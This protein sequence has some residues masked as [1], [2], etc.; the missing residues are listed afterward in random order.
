MSAGNDK[1][2]DW[3]TILYAF[4]NDPRFSV[5]LICSWLTEAEVSSYS[6]VR[7]V[8][9]PTISNFVNLYQQSDIVVV[10][11][12]PN[13]FSGITVALEAA[14]VGVPVISSNTG[15][16][17]TY[18]SSKEVSYVECQ[19]PA[20]L[21]RAALDLSPERRRAQ[22]KRARARFVEDDYS[23]EGMIERYSDITAEILGRISSQDRKRGSNG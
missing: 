22:A 18:F 19:D 1:T 23:S 12:F 2:R 17:A 8:R 7:L 13:L 20:A 21:K 9:D 11:M 10:A 6:N 3:N 14:A 5:V 15:G 4:G 16:V